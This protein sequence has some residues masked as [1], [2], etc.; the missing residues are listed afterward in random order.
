MVLE[1]ALPGTPYLQANGLWQRHPEESFFYIPLDMF[2]SN[3]DQAWR[4]SPRWK[5]PGTRKNVFNI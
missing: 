3:F 1:T 4:C 5:F 2:H